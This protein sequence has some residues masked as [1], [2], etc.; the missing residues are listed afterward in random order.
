MGLDI[1][2]VKLETKE[3]SEWL[4]YDEWPELP[5]GFKVFAMNRVIEAGTKHETNRLV[6][7]FSEVSYQRKGV[8]SSFYK[9]YGPD[10]LLTTLS[11]IVELEK[12][13]HKDYKSSFKSDFTDKFEQGIH[14][15][16]LSY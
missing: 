2:L 8:S 13:I 6:C 15:V 12:H 10:V 5:V 14:L 16:W 3:T 11:E 1:T 9:R 7:Y 4:F